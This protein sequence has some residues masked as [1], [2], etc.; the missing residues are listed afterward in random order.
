MGT[1][2]IGVAQCELLLRLT[3]HHYAD[4]E[5]PDESCGSQNAWD[6]SHFVRDLLTHLSNDSSVE[7]SL[8]LGR[9]DEHADLVSYRAH[10]RHARASQ[11]ARRREVLYV[12]PDWAATVAALSNGRPASAPDLHALLVAHLDD[13]RRHVAGSNID[14][15][16]R[17]WNEDSYGRLVDPKP[18]ESCRH[19][20]VDMLR[21]RL[22]P[23]G[24]LIEPEGHMVADGRAD[25]VAFV[26]GIKIPIEL[27]RDYHADV[28]TAIRTQLQ[29]AYT[30]DRDTS[31]Y[32]IYVVLWFGEGRTRS[33]PGGAIRPTSDQEMERM[34]REAIPADQRE[35]LA[36]IVIDV[37]DPRL[38]RV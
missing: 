14:A 36:V 28:W 3:A 31:G 34:L 10:V 7:A 17:F 25:I 19:V 20:L 18:E 6:A 30:R 26:P 4:T 27:K 16:K 11:H 15:Y 2:P 38:G 12:Q 29:R 8:A 33:I 32:G 22:L 37:S 23:L 21:P 1:P 24:V 5:E 9:L 13:G 35:R